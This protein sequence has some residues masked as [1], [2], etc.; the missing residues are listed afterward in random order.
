LCKDVFALKY[1]YENITRD[2]FFQSKLNLPLDGWDIYDMKKEYMRQGVDETSQKFRAISCWDLADAS[3]ICE[4]Y[5]EYVFIP[6]LMSRM[7][8]TK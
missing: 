6:K 3:N 7:K 2:G 4:T 5:P 8:M 1:L